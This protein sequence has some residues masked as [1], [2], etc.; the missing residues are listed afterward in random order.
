MQNM[1]ILFTIRLLCALNNYKLFNN[2]PPLKITGVLKRKKM[3]L[4]LFS[5]LIRFFFFLLVVHRKEKLENLFKVIFSIFFDLAL[6]NDLF[7]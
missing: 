4:C 5:F 2:P 7:I 1:F 3:S 6:E